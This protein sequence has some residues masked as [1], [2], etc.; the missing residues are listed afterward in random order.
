[1]KPEAQWEIDGYRRLTD[2]DRMR[3]ALRS[4]RLRASAWR[5]LFERVSTS[6]VL[7]TAQMWPFPAEQPWP[8]SIGEA[9]MDTYHRWMEV[10]TFATL[11]GAAR[12]WPCQL[13]VNEDGLHIGLQVIGRP[14][15]DSALLGWADLG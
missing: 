11:G 5:S 12:P 2:A 3:R 14:G 8:S 9:A 1:M 4:R 13:D 6:L 15:G 10:T 7:P